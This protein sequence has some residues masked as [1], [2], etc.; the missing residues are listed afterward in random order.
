[1]T[2]SAARTLIRAVLVVPLSLLAV[3]PSVAAAAEPSPTGGERSEKNDP[4]AAGLIADA[5]SEYDAGR[6]EEARALFKLAHA[7]APTAR[8][9]RGIGMASFEMRDYVE[10]T[11]SLDMSLREQRRPLTADQ[12]RQTEALLQRAEAFVGRFTPRLQPASAALLVDGVPAQREAD[13]SVLLPFGRHRLAARCATC[14]PSEKTV[15]V[16]VAGGEKTDV[17]IALAPFE[18]ATSASG[19]GAAVPAGG[20]TATA[21]SVVGAAPGIAQTAPPPVARNGK[22][23]TALW[24]FGTSALT[25]VGAGASAFY[26]HNRQH[27]LDTCQSGAP[28]GTICTTESSITDQRNLA[29]GL[30]AGLGAAALT[31]GIVGAILWSR[32]DTPPPVALACLGGKGSF[33]CAIQF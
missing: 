17:E 19:G 18:A 16:D 33:A 22:R 20:T 21:S 11:R 1:M 27:E 28:A 8:T 31:T 7:R 13:G 2:F 25:A 15:E 14:I 3:V 12:R 4:E 24:L 9:L 6:F 26:W 10:A 5:V 29:V 30:T 32:R 23:T